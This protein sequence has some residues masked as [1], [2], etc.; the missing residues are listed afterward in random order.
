MQTTEINA[1]GLEHPVRLGAEHGYLVTGDL[2]TINAE[3]HLAAPAVQGT[4]HL[5]LWARNTAHT[6]ERTKP[7]KIAELA[8]ETLRSAL[9]TYRVEETVPAML[10]PHGDYEISLALVR[11]ERETERLIDVSSYPRT[12]RFA[13]PH[14]GGAS[15]YQLHDD[16]TISLHSE[17]LENDRP[18]DNQSGSLRLELWAL[19]GRYDA[20]RLDGHRLAVAEVGTLLGA[21]R[22]ER[23]CFRVAFAEP[24]PGAWHVVLLLREW[25]PSGYQTRDS[26]SFDVLY[27]R[28]AAG[29]QS[30]VGDALPERSRVN[31][32]SL[33]SDVAPAQATARVTPTPAAPAAAA[34][35]PAPAV[36]TP[37]VATPAPAAPTAPRATT[38]DARTSI[39]TASAEELAQVKGLTPKLAREIVRSRP[40]HSLEELVKVK[41]IGEKMLR[42][43]RASLKL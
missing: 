7:L 36:A 34:A 32:R 18:R 27:R 10:P 1:Q 29:E 33:G 19:S 4:W 42:K 35:A 21:A 24:P 38:D 37:A 25:T 15:G 2:V 22:L 14:L 3:L 43:L 20:G 8:L 40:F 17:C 6:A 12:Q 28:E 23:P 39:Q 16:R 11:R 26:A 5:E 30:P 13:G 9:P 31:S 41:G